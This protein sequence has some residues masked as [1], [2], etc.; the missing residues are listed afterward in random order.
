M[1]IA[2]R[3]YADEESNAAITTSSLAVWI[4]GNRLAIDRPGIAC[5][6]G[7]ERRCDLERWRATIPT[8]E[9][10]DPVWRD[11]VLLRQREAWDRCLH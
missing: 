11:H 6:H 7:W 3:S 1:Y 5:V 8:H 10:Q 4:N 9:L 2:L